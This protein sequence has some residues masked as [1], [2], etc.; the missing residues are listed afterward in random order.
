MTELQP[1]DCTGAA[2]RDALEERVMQADTMAQYQQWPDTHQF[3]TPVKQMEGT[4]SLYIL[5]EG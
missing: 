5:H 2:A 1:A 4:L 3:S